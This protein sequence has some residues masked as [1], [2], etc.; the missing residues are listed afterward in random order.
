MREEMKK[1]RPSFERWNK[2]NE[3]LEITTELYNNVVINKVQIVGEFEFVCDECYYK[4]KR[5][6][7]I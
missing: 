5:E 6:L 2:C 3:C 7:D 4:R 1:K